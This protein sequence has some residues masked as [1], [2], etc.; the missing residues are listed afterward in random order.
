MFE[1]KKKFTLQP[2][3]R[4]SCVQCRTHLETSVESVHCAAAASQFYCLPT[5]LVECGCTVTTGSSRGFD[6]PARRHRVPEDGSSCVTQLE[7]SALGWPSGYTKKDNLRHD[8]MQEPRVTILAGSPAGPLRDG[9]CQPADTTTTTVTLRSIN[10]EIK[11]HSFSV[12][13]SPHVRSK[14]EHHLREVNQTALPEFHAIA[15]R[16]T[17]RAS[18]HLKQLVNKTA[19]AKKQR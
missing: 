14:T 7:R 2:V 4:A 19:R 11:F 8:V 1:F 13:K 10:L 15:C 17:Q 5:V 6:Q 9:A 18:Q 12:T 3:Q 16:L